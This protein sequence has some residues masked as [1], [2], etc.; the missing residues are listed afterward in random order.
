MHE[1]LTGLIEKS[2]LALAT[3]RDLVEPGN[4]ETLAALI[5]EARA[6][7]DY[8]EDILVVA[9]AGG[10][11][12]GKSSIFNALTGTAAAG[13]GARRPTTAE[14][15]AAVP[16]GRG[17][18]LEGLLDRLGIGSRVETTTFGHCLIDLPDT[19]SVVVEHRHR[20]EEVLPRIDVMVW[21]LDPEKY[22]DQAIHARYL[23]PLSAYASQFVVVLNQ[24]D[25]LGPAES[26]LV[27]ADLATALVEDGVGDA[28]L[29]AC[30]AGP[31]GLPAQ[32]VDELSDTLETLAGRRH[33]LFEK[34][35]VDLDRAAIG[36][37]HELGTGSG[38]RERATPVLDLAAAMM[39]TGDDPGA[40]RALTGFYE[41]LAAEVGATTG[42]DLTRFVNRIPSLVNQVAAALP[43]PTRGRWWRR[44]PAGADRE[45]MARAGLEA[46]TEPAAAALAA[47]ARAVA[48]VADMSVA[49]RSAMGGGPQ[50]RRRF[51]D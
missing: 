42:S 31:P 30:A 44:P 50:T 1:A 34:L 9:L 12:S 43:A 4:I 5:T 45:A 41:G 23:R 2:E 39:A 37:A 46:V 51:H 19:D 16:A 22:R 49:V 3:T 6:R 24:A 29:L 15:M 7:L 36:L 21:V 18:A 17:A 14:P 26:Q 38:Y 27:L 28:P 32:G 40:V 8:P 20:V 48:A 13:V 25:R 10:T 47:R 11:G 35:L 33:L